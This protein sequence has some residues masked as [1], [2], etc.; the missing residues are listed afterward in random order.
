MHGI[1]HCQKLCSAEEMCVVLDCMDML[2]NFYQNIS[3]RIKNNLRKI[4]SL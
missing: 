4:I 1:I 2:K 3:T